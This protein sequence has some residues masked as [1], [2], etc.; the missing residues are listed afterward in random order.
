MKKLTKMIALAIGL[1]TVAFTGCNHSISEATINGE[2]VSAGTTVTLYA[3]SSD[4]VVTFSN[5]SSNNQRTIMPGTIDGTSSNYKFYLWGTDKLDST[6]TSISTPTVVTFTATSGSTTKGSVNLDL[7]VSQWELY[8]AVIPATETTPTTPEAAKAKAVLFASAIVDFRSSDSVNF[9]L[10]PYKLSGNGGFALKIYNKGWSTPA[11]HTV[12]IGVWPLDADDSDDTKKTTGTTIST[13]GVGT[14]EPDDANFSSESTTAVPPGTYNLIVKYI[15]TA[16][17]GLTKTYYYS[18]RLVILSNQ[19]TSDTIAIPN[20]LTNPPTEPEKLGVSFIDPL[21]STADTYEVQFN[22][23]DKSYNEDYF[24]L[25]ILDFTSLEET[26]YTTLQDSFTALAGATGARG[27]TL[28]TAWTTITGDSYKPSETVYTIGKKLTKT[29]SSTTTDMGY[30]FNNPSFWVDG[31]MNKNNSYTVLKLSTGH[32]Y[33]ARLCAVNDIGKSAYLYADIAGTTVEDPVAFNRNG[34]TAVAATALKKFGANSTE[35]NRFRI[36]YNL[37]EGTFYEKSSTDPK[38]LVE[39]NAELANIKNINTAKD[40]IIVYGT[41]NSSAASQIT[42]LNALHT[43]NTDETPKYAMLYNGDMN[44]W[45]NWLE[46]STSSTTGYSLSDSYLT[47]ANLDSTTTATWTEAAYTGFANLNLYASYR[48]TSGNAYIDTSASYK[49]TDGMVKVFYNTT[50]A[51]PT[52]PVAATKSDVGVYTFVNDTEADANA[53]DGVVAAKYL[54]VCLVNDATNNVVNGTG[55]AYD[56]VIVKVL[57]NGRTAKQTSTA[58]TTSSTIAFTGVNASGAATTA[59]S[60]SY[61]TVPIGTY[62]AGKYTVQILAYANTQQGEYTYNLT[63]EV[64]D[65]S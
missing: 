16:A 60:A 39:P 64:R 33:L 62:A 49:I 58:T 11:T 28:D 47:N 56:K 24:Q 1:V 8:L 3:T 4:N 50:A 10:S 65:P 12:K 46:N 63:F 45:T 15:P 29:V 61:V 41:R 18:D 57:K 2:G 21:T 31:A 13:T 22:W 59:A 26:N 42:I 30:Y 40:A 51:F 27:S 23:T 20:I 9:F 43:P 7:A 19:V 32:R 53:G 5:S 54:Y 52:T 38:K 6:N 44:R 17:S 36:T 14:T 34:T 48:V 35:I 37:N 25:E 55:V